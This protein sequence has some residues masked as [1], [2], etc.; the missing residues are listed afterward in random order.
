MKSVDGKVVCCVN[1]EIYNHVEI[2]ATCDTEE[3]PRPHRPRA[4]TDLRQPLDHPREREAG[5]G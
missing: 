1:G 3:T 4:P 2:K 5:R